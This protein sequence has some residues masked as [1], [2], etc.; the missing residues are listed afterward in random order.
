MSLAGGIWAAS[1]F[2]GRNRLGN[3]PLPNKGNMTTKEHKNPTEEAW[4][5]FQA[6]I[7]SLLGRL[8]K[9]IADDYRASGLEDSDQPSMDVT[10]GASISEDGEISWSYQ[11]GDN[12]Y[13]GG[14]YGHPFWG[15]SGIT[16]E[17]DPAF[18]A[19][20]IVDQIAD[21]TVA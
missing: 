13:T 10:V 15:V 5:S 12:S 21:Q 20:A 1:G 8:Q 9:D 19:E 18:I 16:R 2:R 17:D 3:E 11:T 6:E 7:A 4:N 14:A